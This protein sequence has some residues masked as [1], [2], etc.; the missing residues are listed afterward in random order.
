MSA[1]TP[2]DD[3]SQGRDDERKTSVCRSGSV[4]GKVSEQL[5]FACRD[6]KA[7]SHCRGAKSSVCALTSQVGT[8]A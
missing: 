1:Q 5:Q 8:V 7:V 2:F 4:N 3:P 6:I